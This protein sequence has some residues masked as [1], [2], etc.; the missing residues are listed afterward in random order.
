MHQ[1]VEGD[2]QG[3]RHIDAEHAELLAHVFIEAMR[4]GGAEGRRDA[5]AI[6]EQKGLPLRLAEAHAHEDEN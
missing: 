1:V 4:K 3:S 5:H 6:D 2:E